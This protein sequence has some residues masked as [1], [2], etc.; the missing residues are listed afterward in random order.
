MVIVGFF[1]GGAAV[2]APNTEMPTAS[3]ITYQVATHGMD[4]ADYLSDGAL[5]LPQDSPAEEAEKKDNNNSAAIAL[6]VVMAMVPAAAIL[7]AVFLLRNREDFMR[8]AFSEERRAKRER[9]ERRR[10]DEPDYPETDTN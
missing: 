7:S 3:P 1:S 9:E 4:S 2:A 5:A 6:G 8:D 10:P